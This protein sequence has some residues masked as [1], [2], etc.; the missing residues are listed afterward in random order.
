M[1][2]KYKS[3]S[4]NPAAVIKVFRDGGRPLA[5]AEVL[6]VLGGTRDDMHAL[7]IVLGE[8][9]DQGRIIRLKGGSFG[10]TDEMRL[11]PGTLHI[12]R[13]KVGFVI[14]EDKRRTDIFINPANFGDAWHGDRVVVAILPESRGRRTEGRVV[15]V[16]ERRTGAI[17]TVVLRRLGAALLCQPTDP[18]QPMRFMV[19]DDV[20]LAGSTIAL[21]P[22]DVFLVQPGERIE[23][24]L[25]SAGVLKILG[26]ETDAVVQEE[27]VKIGHG[28]PTIFSDEA[29]SEAAALPEIPTAAD[30]VGRED[31]RERPFV[32]IDGA[33]AKDLDDA[34]LVERCGRGF[35]LLVAIADVSHYVQPGS[36]LDVEAVIRGNSYYFPQSV[37]PMFPKTLSNGLCSLKPEVPRLAIVAEIEFSAQGLPGEARFYN[38]VI[39]S[40]AQLT[41]G[42][43]QRA[44]F[45]KD[46]SERNAIAH[47]LPQL[48]LAVKLARQINV[49]RSERG[50]LDFDLPEPEIFFSKEGKIIDIRPKGRHFG[51]QII[52]EYMIAVN[53]AVAVFLTEQGLPFFYRI[54]PDPDQDKLAT[55][56]TLLRTLELCPAVPVETT[57]QGLQSIL[58]A[59]V[60][61]PMEFL[62]NRMTLRTMMQA[63]YSPLHEGHF[64][65]ASACYC[66]FTSPIRRYAD[67]V[68]HRSLKIALARSASMRVPW[69]HPRGLQKLGNQLSD[70][71]RVAMDAER[72]IVKRLTI[73]F[74]QDRIGEKFSGVV[75]SV[76]DFGFWVELKEVM[77]E[78]FVRLSSITDDYYCLLSDRQELRGERMGRRFYVGREVQVQLTEV[79]LGRLEVS[80][81]LT[82]G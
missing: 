55:L 32:T 66:H 81:E 58:Q 10:L 15:R 11:I 79:N 37:E 60:G 65:L 68:V 25:W 45:I 73:I 52:E 44:L 27:I 54:H 80:L 17:P 6:H 53:E 33:K 78:G 82:E 28:V 63:K 39:R 24:N 22:G 31:L 12:Q 26:P 67:L 46:Q 19:E 7:Y 35:T 48:E 69:L 34:I 72:E 41:Y 4:I 30:M 47:V 75:S 56:F 77:A 38:A 16:V 29:V 59:A 64:G 20:M 3:A 36:A 40:H 2:K 8:L 23:H 14:P 74:L 57:P 49:R 21:N 1:R 42:Q 9:L 5:R 61:T 51:H 43:V 71:E 50:S 76:A 62:V 70:L 13:S 18:R